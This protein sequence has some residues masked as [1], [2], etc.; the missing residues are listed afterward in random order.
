M[1]KMCCKW[2]L[3]NISLFTLLGCASTPTYTNIT[4][5]VNLEQNRQAFTNLQPW[6]IDSQDLRIA[7]HV[8]EITDGDGVA[9]LIN[10]QQ[11]L[12][13]LVEK[14]LTKAWLENGLK[15]DAN[16]DYQVDIKLVKAIA[17][18]TESTFSYDASSQM[19]VDVA[20]THRGKHF[21]KIFRSNKQW[22]GVFSNQIDG[23]TDQLN[24]QLS[25]LLKQI[26]EDQELNSQL[27]QF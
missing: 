20:L 13:L 1:F 7:R 27:Q 8:I 10:E 14:S 21:H 2:L 22:D 15:T 25:L 12:R 24:K 5:Q 18:V 23:I 11:S 16:S 26:I 3:L 17:K 19:V 4:P 9:K 6:K